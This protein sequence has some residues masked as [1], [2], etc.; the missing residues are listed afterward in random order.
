[1]DAMPKSHHSKI[2]RLRIP[3]IQS[4]NLRKK[5][6]DGEISH[7]EILK[8]VHRSADLAIFSSHIIC[9]G[10]DCQVYSEPL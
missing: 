4:S 10:S 8:K 1:M 6:I 2:W 7:N 5:I 9:Q 3:N